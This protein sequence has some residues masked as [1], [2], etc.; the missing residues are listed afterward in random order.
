MKNTFLALLALLFLMPSS[1]VAGTPIYIGGW[2]VVPNYKTETVNIKI[3]KLMNQ[4]SSG[5]SGTL[6]IEV[7]ITDSPI[8]NRPFNGWKIAYYQTKALNAGASYTNINVNPPLIKRA[9]SGNKYMTLLV[10]EYSN[11]A[12]RTVAKSKSV[13]YQVR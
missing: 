7:W 13:P 9:G 11:G 2:Y 5:Y 4:A 3:S 1:A 10:T 6:R 12:Y 8:G